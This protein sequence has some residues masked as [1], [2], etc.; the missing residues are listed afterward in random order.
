M[1]MHHEEESRRLR[2]AGYVRVPRGW[3]P[4]AYAERVQAQ[5]EAH[6]ADVVRLLGKPPKPRGRPRKEISDEAR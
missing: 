6:A 5:I 4:A 1:T 2:A 3:V